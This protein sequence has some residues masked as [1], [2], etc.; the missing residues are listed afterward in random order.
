MR[1]AALSFLGGPP[2]AD[3][4]KAA[5]LARHL[6]AGLDASLK[7]LSAADRGE[8]LGLIYEQIAGRLAHNGKHERGGHTAA[9]YDG[10]I[11]AWG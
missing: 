4:G 1:A 9:D 8:V 3:R 10:G 6:V 2:P 7:D 5:A 11:A